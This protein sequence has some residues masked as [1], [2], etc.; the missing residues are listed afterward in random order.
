MVLVKKTARIP[1][2]KTPSTPLG[3]PTAPTKKLERSKAAI[4]KSRQE[5]L[6]K[7]TIA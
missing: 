3:R 7:A 1:K 5:I 2:A 4:K 6:P